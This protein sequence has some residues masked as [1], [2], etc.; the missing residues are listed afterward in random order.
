MASLRQAPR[1]TLFVIIE[2]SS[3][4]PRH[5]VQKWSASSTMAKPSGLTE[6]PEV[7]SP[8]GLKPCATPQ[9]PSVPPA[10]VCPQARGPQRR[11]VWGSD[12]RLRGGEIKDSEVDSGSLAGTH[13][14]PLTGT[15]FLLLWRSETAWS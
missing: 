14:R 6:A 1:I 4:P 7:V 8:H 10:D 2:S 15:P 3:F 5:C 12:R 11:P 13:D 9:S